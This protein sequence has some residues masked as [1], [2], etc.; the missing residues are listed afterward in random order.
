MPSVVVRSFFQKA[1]LTLSPRGPKT[2]VHFELSDVARPDSAP[3]LETVI[4]LCQESDG[5]RLR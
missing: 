1:T 3:S 4:Q 2:A 5:V